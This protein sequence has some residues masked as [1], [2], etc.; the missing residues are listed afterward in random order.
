[1]TLSSPQDPQTVDPD[2]AHTEMAMAALDGLMPEALSRCS[3]EVRDRFDNAL[4]NVAVNR[5]IAVEGA[6]VLCRASQSSE[7]FR[8]VLERI[9]PE[10]LEGTTARAA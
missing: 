9:V 7:P 8:R 10:L 6:L 2:I 1:M 5:I 3:P 4:L